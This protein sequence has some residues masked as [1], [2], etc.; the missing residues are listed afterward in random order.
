[1]DTF[2]EDLDESLSNRNVCEYTLFQNIFVHTLDKQVTIKKKKIL[3]FNK[4]S[5]MKKALRKA[6]TRRSNFKN[7]YHK[8]WTNENW[9]IYKKQKNFCVNLLRATTKEYLQG[10]NVTDLSDNKKIWKT[11]TVYLLERAPPF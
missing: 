9:A 4:N 5:F 6:I 1:M 3:R 10:L 8:S 7:V 11:I 2:K